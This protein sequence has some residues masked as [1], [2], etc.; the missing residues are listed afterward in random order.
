MLDWETHTRGLAAAVVRPE[1]RWF[2]PLATTPRHVF[3]P[4]W[5]EG[6]DT[7]WE[8]RDGA[9]DVAGWMAAAYSDRT[10]VTRVG[11]AH[12]DDS[13]PGSGVGGGLPTSSSTLPGLVVNMYR[14]AML[15]DDCHT[16]VPKPS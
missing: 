3:V 4:R 2:G 9:S 11:A 12:A 1:S 5:W 7:K 13:D 10:L 15:T 8:Q 14:H 6:G 16:L